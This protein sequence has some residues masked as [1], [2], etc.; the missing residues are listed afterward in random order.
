MQFD[1]IEGKERKIGTTLN[2]IL[3]T[4]IFIIFSS[5]TE[6]TVKV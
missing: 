1:V 2:F 6:L 5:I 3:Q 4:T